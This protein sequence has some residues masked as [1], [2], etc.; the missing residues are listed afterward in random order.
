MPPAHPDYDPRLAG[1]R[2]KALVHIAMQDEPGRFPTYEAWAAHV[3]VIPSSV[4]GWFSGRQMPR[5][6]ILRLAYL[7]PL[8]G[9]HWIWLGERDSIRDTRLR[10]RLEAEVEALLA[11]AGQGKRRKRSRKPKGEKSRAGQPEPRRR[12]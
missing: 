11:E 9:A 12:P 6:V 10:E 1:L 4:S 7:Y 8:I 2:V 5:D 3:G